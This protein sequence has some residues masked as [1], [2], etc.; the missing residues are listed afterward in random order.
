MVHSSALVTIDMYACCGGGCGICCCCH[1]TCLHA[2]VV[3]TALIVGITHACCSGGHSTSL[4]VMHVCVCTEVVRSLS[5]LQVRA[6]VVAMAFVAIV[7]MHVCMQAVVM[8]KVSVTTMSNS[9]SYPVTPV[10][11]QLCSSTPVTHQ[12]LRSRLR[13]YPSVKCDPWSMLCSFITT[14][15]RLPC[16]DMSSL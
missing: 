9:G 15:R 5:S 4:Q 3:A 11:S 7:V 1:R 16:L 14:P 12:L 8:V 13:R 10:A 2:V 6:E